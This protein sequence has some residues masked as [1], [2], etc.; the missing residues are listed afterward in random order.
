MVISNGV[1][2]LFSRGTKHQAAGETPGKY[3]T[4][5]DFKAIDDALRILS[6]VFSPRRQ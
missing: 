2:N 5:K 3:N 6:V 4:G 1:R